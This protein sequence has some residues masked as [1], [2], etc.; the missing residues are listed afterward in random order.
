LRLCALVVIIGLS[1]LALGLGLSAIS[2]KRQA[3]ERRVEV[4]GLMGFMLG[5]FAEK[6]RP[7]AR[8][9]LLD[10]VGARALDYYAKSQE[11]DLSQTALTQRA[12]ALHVLAEVRLTRGDPQAAR[13]ALT[14]AQQILLKQLAER[15]KDL[16][17]LKNLANNVTELG[18]T[19][20]IK[21]EWA[22][23]APYYA[24]RLE[25]SDLLNRLDPDNPEWW[26]YQ[27]AA[28]NNAGGLAFR[29]LNFRAAN[30]HFL[31]GYELIQ[32][33][34]A[35]NPRDPTLKRDS[36]TIVSWLGT[37]QSQYGKLPEAMQLH[38]QEAVI[39]GSLH[40]ENPRDALWAGDLS[41]ALR[42]QADL[43]MAFGQKAQ[44]LPLY[45]E[46]A[47][48]L[49]RSLQQEPNNQEW[50]R[51]LAVAQMGIQAALP[52]QTDPLTILNNLQQISQITTRLLQI[53]PNNPDWVNRHTGLLLR[54][55]N[56]LLKMQRN[57]EAEQQLDKAEA[58]QEKLLARHTTIFTIKLTM[59][60]LL[61]SRAELETRCG[62]PARARLSCLR[63]QNLLADAV[64]DSADYHLL[65]PW[66]RLHLCLNDSEAA[67][68]AIRKLA[69]I[70][71]R[72][73]D[74]LQK[75]ADG[76]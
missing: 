60:G 31:T 47:R 69:A 48:L 45:Q 70:G 21:S 18:K 33:A 74:Y 36:A 43:Y 71:Y 68:P 12:L 64:K 40:Q 24:K 39:L 35:K 46:M 4:E 16:V 32:R 56:H 27:S 67:K 10:S 20:I 13:T 37:L 38:Q 3:Q 58:L 34:R 55:V 51:N 26:A 44:A 23:A 41:R 6:L 30:T 28:H 61:L 2:A 5:D 50:L 17:I 9:D 72:E 29:Q 54:Q 76:K 75:I 66:V 15:P 49:N 73:A 62:N 22:L 57:L 65:D 53:D 11:E 52:E 19:H 59:A 1:L 7:L 14:A 42:L 25:Y 63:G 8:L